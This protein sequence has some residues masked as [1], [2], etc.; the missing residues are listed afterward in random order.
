MVSA[1]HFMVST[2]ALRKVVFIFTQISSPKSWILLFQ[3][4]SLAVGTHSGDVQIWDTVKSKKINT[5]SGHTTRVGKVV[6][7]C[8]HLKIIVN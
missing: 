6:V 5:L 2:E 8:S 7:P 3:G 4:D 1:K